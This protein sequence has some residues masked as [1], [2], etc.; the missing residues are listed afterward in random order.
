[1]RYRD[2]GWWAV[3]HKGNSTWSDSK[4]LVQLL[5][6]VYAF[7]KARVH[8]MYVRPASYVSNYMYRLS[9]VYILR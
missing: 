2:L 1:M 5:D 9:T 8:K 3:L 4:I 7:G 6:T